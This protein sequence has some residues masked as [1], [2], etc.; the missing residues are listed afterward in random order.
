VAAGVTGAGAY[1]LRIAWPIGLSFAL[2]VITEITRAQPLPGE[3]PAQGPSSPSMSGPMA[4]ITALVLCVL[5]YE[6]REAPGRLR[7]SRRMAAAAAAIDVLQRPPAE[8]ADRY[9]ALLA[10]VPTGATVAVW[11]SEP[12]RLDYA[13][14]RIIDLRTPAGARLRSFR[15]EAHAS[16]LESLLAELGAGFLLVEADHARVLRTQSDLLYR[17]LCPAMAE[18]CADDL[19]SI[20]LRHREIADRDDVTLVALHR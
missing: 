9:R 6:G 8:P 14:L 15:W 11:V 7:W 3:P 10:R 1:S 16:K 18:L 13:R 19:E 17:L 4:L 20:A 12:E 5:I 2:L